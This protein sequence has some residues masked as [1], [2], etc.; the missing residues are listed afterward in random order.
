MITP[1]IRRDANLLRPTWLLMD[2]LGGSL[3]NTG[4]WSGN[5]DDVV[6]PQR[7]FLRTLLDGRP[8]AIQ[9]VPTVPVRIK[10]R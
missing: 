4:I 10:L 6:S 7:T 3:T 8:W 5:R 1:S 9:T 2:I